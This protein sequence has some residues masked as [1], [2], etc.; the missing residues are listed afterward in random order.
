MPEYFT[1]PELAERW[2]VS[3][4][5]IRRKLASGELNP[6][7]IGRVVRIEASEV[8]RIEAVWRG[9]LD[10]NRARWNEKIAERR[11]AMEDDA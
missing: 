10:A 11:Q 5:T 7:Y 1:L 9:E 6:V 2:K 3:I 8:E 4:P